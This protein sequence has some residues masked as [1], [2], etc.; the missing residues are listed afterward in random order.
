[1]PVAQ[2]MREYAP[3]RVSRRFGIQSDADTHWIVPSSLDPSHQRQDL[4][5]H[6]FCKAFSGGTVQVEGDDGAPVDYPCLRPTAYEGSQVGESVRN[7]SNAFL[8]WRTQICPFAD[9]ETEPVSEAIHWHEIIP[10]VSFYTHGN[11]APLEIRRFALAS[12]A[13]IGFKDDREDLNA[14]IR[15][16]Q[17]G[18]PVALG[19]TQEVD[20]VSFRVKVPDRFDVDLA[21]LESRQART[22]KT[23]YYEHRLQ[24]SDALDD[25]ANEFQRGWLYQLSLAAVSQRAASDSSSLEA[26]FEKLDEEGFGGAMIDVLE[27]IFKSLPDEADSESREDHIKEGLRSLC[28]HPI[29]EQVV[30][31]KI[32]V[33]WRPA[34]REDDWEE[35]LERRFLTSLGNA[36]LEACT[37]LCPESEGGE[38]LLDIDEGPRPPGATQKPDDLE[39]IWI[40]ERTLGGGGVVDQ[41]R[42]E[43]R[44]DPRRFYQFV[45]NALSASDL[46]LVDAELQTVLNL[47]TS[48]DE[49]Q[50]ALKRV[51][52]AR[53]IEDLQ[54]ANANLRNVLTSRG[55]LGI[56]PVYAGL[57]NRILRPGSSA[58]TDRLL[59]TLIRDW[60]AAE[61]RLGIEIDARVF[62][63]TASREKKYTEALASVDSDAAS[64]A[65]WRFQT[66]YSLLWPRGRKVREREMDAYNPFADLPSGDR[67]LITEHLP[68][69][70]PPVDIDRNGWKKR[71]TERLSDRGMARLSASE[72]GRP[73]LQNALVTLLS[74]P[75]DVD[76]LRLYPQLSGVEREEGGFVA[77]MV[78]PEV[79]Q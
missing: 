66:I 12:D 34:D 33:L 37:L 61:Q 70:R 32:P 18:V 77:T 1:M 14:R 38:L 79:V 19:F 36:L 46:E 51:R 23:A 67:L 78:L 41:I 68:Q 31:E 60:Q 42:R 7:S 47:A 76:F 52:R 3:G 69:R 71:V 13:E 49:V 15:F 65:E 11:H 6:S 53:G 10:E 55:M 30:S 40:T 59:H 63:Y 43:Y 62:A 58:Q 8:D 27:H 17:D 56:H 54:D 48:N 44:K 22:L 16:V 29:V 2:A 64:D 57:Q 39:E 35:W 28:V 75:V 45:E 72:S 74:E 50:D 25:L 24:S 4:E 20:G 5:V 26:A 73:G 21:N 9:G